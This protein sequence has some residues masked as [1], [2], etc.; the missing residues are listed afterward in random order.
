MYTIIHK[1]LS[2]FHGD[3]KNANFN[4][5]QASFGGFGYFA[6][7]NFLRKFLYFP[8]FQEKIM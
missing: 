7:S 5:K 2:E 4:T 3:F 6:V 8:L 1:K